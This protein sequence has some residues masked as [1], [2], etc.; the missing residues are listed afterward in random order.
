[1]LVPP[2]P[3]VLLIVVFE[4][5]KIVVLAMVLFC[6]D[7]IRLI[8]LTGPSVVVIVLFVVIS[9]RGIVVLGSQGYWRYCNW[10][11]KCGA[12][13]GCIPET[14]HDFVFLRRD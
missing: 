8:F 1:M 14:R 9:A 11:H 13:Q 12:Q 4:L 7:A 3:V 10:G 2:V 5:G 6:I